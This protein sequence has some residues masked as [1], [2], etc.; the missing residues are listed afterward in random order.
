MFICFS[1]E[2]HLGCFSF[3]LYEQVYNSC[4]GCLDFLFSLQMGKQQRGE[5]LGN[6]VHICLTNVYIKEH[7]PNERRQDKSQKK[8]KKTE[9]SNFPDKIKNKL[10]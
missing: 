9:I 3:R 5:F 4:T 1:I 7:F 8:L 6:K 2:G 10:S